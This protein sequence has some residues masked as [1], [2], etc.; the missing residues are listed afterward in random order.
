MKQNQFEFKPFDKVL[1][2]DHDT[3]PWKVNFFSH[4]MPK[5]VDKAYVCAAGV[6]YQCIPY[7]ENTAHLLGTNQPYK[8][9]EPKIWNV[10]NINAGVHHEFTQSQFE[11]FIKDILGSKECCAYSIHRIN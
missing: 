7:N 11:H 2:R 3:H 5:Q 9:P 10:K 4:Y 6:F 1:V 8:E